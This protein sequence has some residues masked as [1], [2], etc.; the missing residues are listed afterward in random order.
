MIL[1]NEVYP[2]DCLIYKSLMKPDQRYYQVEGQD[3]A[4]VAEHSPTPIVSSSETSLQL[5]PDKSREL[6]SQNTALRTESSEQNEPKPA[7]DIIN[8]TINQRLTHR[9]ARATSLQYNALDQAIEDAKAVQDLV[10]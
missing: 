1:V 4:P 2:S 9:L 8:N 3:V 5:K 10:S 6:Q 7:D